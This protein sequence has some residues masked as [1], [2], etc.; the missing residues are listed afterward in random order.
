MA[1]RCT[2]HHPP[3]RPID[4]SFLRQGSGSV[5]TGRDRR[6]TP[7]SGTVAASPLRRLLHGPGQAAAAG[8][9]ERG[10]VTTWP[11]FLV[12]S[13]LA[14]GHPRLRAHQMQLS[15]SPRAG[16]LSPWADAVRLLLSR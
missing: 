7:T 3:V 2:L 9:Q 12:K 13:V 8:C 6:W 5:R 11:T 16:P 4:R 15:T 10:R 14:G 1:L